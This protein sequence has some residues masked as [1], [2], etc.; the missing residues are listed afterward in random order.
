MTEGKISLEPFPQDRILGGRATIDYLL[1]RYGS[2]T[3]HP[4][5]EENIFIVA[6]GI[7]A[8]T[9]APQSG[10]LSVGGKSPL[11]GG[12]KEANVGGTAA[13]KLGRLGIMGI[14][15]EGKAK[16][17]QVLKI[18]SQGASLEKAAGIVGLTNYSACEMLRQK[19]GDKIG[20]IIIGP[21]GEMKLANSTVAVTDPEGRPS[22]HAARGGVGAIMG[23]KGLKAVVIDDDGGSLR[24]AVH[25]EAFRE[26]AKKAAE[27]IQNFPLRE[28]IHNM[29][30]ALFVNV[31]NGR[32]S[33]PTRNHREG[34]FEKAANLGPAKLVEL[35][36]ARGGAMGHGCLPGCVVRCSPIFHDPSGKFLTAAL[37]YETISMLGSNLG[38]DDLDAVARMDRKCDDLG[39]D[40]IE[41][42][43][44]I[45]V[46]NDA[47]LFSFGDAA[48][49]ESLIDEIA[50]GTPLGRVLGSGVAVTARVFGIER[51]PAVKGQGIPAH[52]ARSSKGW[53]VTYATSPQGADHTAGSVIEEPLSNKG[54]A[55]RSRKA[56]IMT[57]AL[58]A[59][60]LCLFTFLMP[61]LIFPM[62]NALYGISW[63]VED[64]LDMGKEMLR[65][66]RAFNLKAGIGP[67]A[68]R[69]P[70]WMS[71]EPLPPTKAVFDVPEEDLLSVFHF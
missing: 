65:Q 63:T 8:G 15:V 5:S 31:D 41:M 59:T 26:A 1:T 29:G 42:G 71:K 64:Y 39:L 21:A 28:G 66:E 38:I 48:K 60:G 33:F 70:D 13:H 62:I 45:G 12:I 6:P 47:G 23:A 18:N 20:I 27:A 22:R 67:E 58:D 16:E 43:C 49:A 17:W 53:G 25:E 36:K 37:E 44:T 50:K 52:A 4:L 40:T 7:L 56:Q 54:Q 69:L 32:G 57:A 61:K 19:Y 68:D 2:P 30:T 24:K 9:S 3:A 51:V 11:T 10:R 34:S 46:L 55:E 35:V 14:L